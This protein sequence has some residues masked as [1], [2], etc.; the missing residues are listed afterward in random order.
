[1]LRGRHLLLAA[2]AAAS[3]AAVPSAFACGSSGYTYAGLA[4][5]TRSHGVSA[6]VTAIGAPSVQKG[7]VAG[8]VGVGGPKQGPNGSDEWIQVG[9]SGFTGTSASSLYYEVARPGM[10]TSYHEIEAGLPWGTSRRLAVLEMAKSPNMWR[11]WVNGRAV[12][13]PVHLPGSHGAWRG[14]ATAESWGGG[15]FSCN[16]FA[17]RFDRIAVAQ[18]AGGS[19]RTLSSALP[20]LSSGFRFDR[21]SASSFVAV[22]G[23]VLRP[24]RTVATAAISARAT[25]PAA[26]PSAPAPSSPAPSAAPAGEPAAGGTLLS[27]DPV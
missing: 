27:L 8:W 10:P 11:V 1:V 9:F 16:R 21:P 2:V 4:S 6:K 25:S 20:I 26:A 3:L 19:W 24:T 12:S 22:S 15:S 18:R 17:Y 13:R 14:I 5:A 23:T 7:H